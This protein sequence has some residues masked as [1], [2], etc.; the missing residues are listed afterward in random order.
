MEVK[1]RSERGSKTNKGRKLGLIPAVVY[2]KEVSPESIWV[3]NLDLK[4]LLKKA[5]ESTLIDLSIENKAAHKV[6]V[7]DIQKDPVNGKFLHVDFFQVKMNEKIETEVELEFVGESIAVK[8]QAGVLVKNMDE[9]EVSCLPG[10]LPS[11]ITVDI[12][13]L[14]TFEDRIC[15]K[16]LKVGKGVEIKLDPETV[17]ALVAPQRKEEELAELETKVEADV[18]KVEGVVKEAPKEEEKK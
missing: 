17:I 9:V 5:G 13:A 18:T 11:S 12:S 8:E 7:Y 6:L 1:L 2:G 16:D 10:D 4:R 3:N 14:K 15:V